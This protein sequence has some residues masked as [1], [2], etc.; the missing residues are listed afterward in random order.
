MV[1]QEEVLLSINQKKLKKLK[2]KKEV[3]EVILRKYGQIML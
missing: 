1:Q 2:L 3:R